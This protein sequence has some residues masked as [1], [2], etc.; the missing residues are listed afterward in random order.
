MNSF[1]LAF[2]NFRNNIKLFKFNVL[3]MIFAIAVFFNFF[4][5]IYNP[6]L[7]LVG[8]D[9]L[10]IKATLYMTSILLVFFILFFILYSNSFFL[11]QRKREIGIYTFMGVDNSQIALVFA[12]EEVVLGLVSLIFGLIF[13]MIFQKAFLMLLTKVAAFKTEVTF[14]LSINSIIITSVV[15]LLMF[16]LAAV[17]GFRSILKSKLIEL[18]NSEKQEDKFLKTRYFTGIISIVL[19][20]IG[21]F[22]S[23]NIFSEDFFT[24]GSI[25]IFS[26]ILGTFMLFNSFLSI[27]IKFMID[28]KKILYKGTNIISISNI[29][30]RIRY[31]YKTLACITIIVAATITSIG[32]AFTVKHMFNSIIKIEYPYSFSYVSSDKKL[33]EKVLDIIDSSKHDVLLNIEAKYL[34]FDSQRN[35]R[36][37]K[38]YPVIKYSDFNRILKNLKV[39]NMDE[40]IK[41]SRELQDGT[42]LSV[43]SSNDSGFKNNQSLN[44][45][46]LNV[47]IKKTIS[48][49]LL[50]ARF[51]NNTI[52]L[53][54]KD[55]DRFKINC[56]NISSPEEER[57][58]NGIIVSN[59][60][61]SLELSKKLAAMPALKNNFNSYITYYNSFNEVIGVV[62]FTGLF[63]GVVFMLSTASIMYMK[64]ISDA[65][66]DKRKYEILMKLGMNERELHGAISK[67]VGLSYAIPLFVGSLYALMGIKALQEFLNKYLEISL[68]KPF[69]VSLVIYGIIYIVSYLLTTKKFIKL[70]TS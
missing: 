26:I 33:K 31:N 40:V 27:V 2:Y 18:L 50:G 43:V 70:V 57:V 35:T 67:Q 28:N 11:K 52:V 60:D 30:Y 6:F 49:P 64:I 53:T 22:Y 7:N 23:K 62:G 51:E 63:L 21:Y 15:F 48:A 4:S 5:L 34:I 47:K 46:G 3:S 68:M 39:D 65:I 14:Y 45:Y 29:A 13:G 69:L 66:G 25:V 58:F 9:K 41:N 1:K 16:S 36:S 24:N 20:I 17:V 10:M 42:A 61:Y 32:A 56:S 55:Y 54:D 8:T 37:A 44:M 19:I 59:Q 12:I 38:N